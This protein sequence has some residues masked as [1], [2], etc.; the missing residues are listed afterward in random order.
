VGGSVPSPEGDQLVHRAGTR[1][2]RSPSLRLRLTSNRLLTLK[3]DM[4]MLR[5]IYSTTSDQ[6]NKELTI[7]YRNIQWQ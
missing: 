6:D 2:R 3:D 5:A 1:M 7:D 4:K